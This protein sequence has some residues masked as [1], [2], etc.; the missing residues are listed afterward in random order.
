MGGM[1]IFV[2]LLVVAGL[3]FYVV[4]EWPAGAGGEARK[5]YDATVARLTPL[6]PLLIGL[7]WIAYGCMHIASRDAVALDEIPTVTGHDELARKAVFAASGGLEI[8]LGLATIGTRWRKAALLAELWLLLAMTPF[9]VYLLVDAQAMRVLLGDLLPLGWLRLV[10]VFH[11]MLLLVWIRSTYAEACK[12]VPGTSDIAT[13]PAV[14]TAPPVAPRTLS[15]R[16]SPVTIVACV[17]LAANVAGFGA[18]A[19]S[20]WHAA[21]LD[22][23]A[24]GCLA[25][26]GL[27]GFL[28][29]VPRWVR[30]TNRPTERYVPNANIEK[31]SD[32]LTKTIVGV[33]L[34]ELHGL[35]AA[36]NTWSHQVADGLA[37]RTGRSATLDEARAFAAALI[38]YFAAAGIIESFLLT[39]MFLTR[40]W[41]HEEEEAAEEKLGSRPPASPS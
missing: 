33:G 11:N 37:V 9:V 2:S 16:I 7:V 12:T 20:P 29:G 21:V 39:R 34:V 40:V 32:W 38:V 17:L 8:V 19:A 6:S 36:I 14:I 1:G 4:R 5:R 30:P 24:M 26:G 22:L 28:F 23:W 10:V 27:L 35:G 25:C 31:L 3:V 18:I 13:P 15:R 41:Q